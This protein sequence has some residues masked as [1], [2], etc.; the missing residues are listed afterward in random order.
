M[1]GCRIGWQHLEVG[2]A[3]TE[4]FR[5]APTTI[6]TSPSSSIRKDWLWLEKAACFWSV[7]RGEA[8]GLSY[9]DNRGPN[10][11]SQPFFVSSRARDS[12]MT[13]WSGCFHLDRGRALD[14]QHVTAALIWD[15]VVPGFAWFPW[16]NNAN[17]HGSS[18]VL[19]LI[20]I[21]DM[22]VIFLRRFSV[23]IGKVRTHYRILE[24][25]S[26]SHR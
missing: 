5:L 13:G 3:A 19:T 6:W 24:S 25:W 11:F 2:D 26:P 20:R 1:S 14:L 18:Q 12:F 10:R 17:E 7:V 9:I 15:W 23:Q 16:T 21:G 4:R 8:F 22:F